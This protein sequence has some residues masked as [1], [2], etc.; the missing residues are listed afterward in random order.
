MSEH[1]ALRAFGRLIVDQVEGL[2]A[3]NADQVERAA[4]L[5]VQAQLSGR[6]VWAAGAG[7]SLGGVL[8]MFFR[9]GGLPSVNPLWHPEILPLNGAAGSTMAERRVGLGRAVVA[10]SAIGPKDVV[11]VFSNSGINHYP[12][13]VAAE[14]R[15]LGAF[16]VAVTSRMASLQA[17]LRAGQRL[18][19]LA[20]VVLDTEVPPGDVVWPPSGARVAPLSSIA[21]AVCWNMVM[22]AASELEPELQ[23]W[24]SANTGGPD[25]HNDR[26]RA[27]YLAKV[28]AL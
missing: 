9:A 20:D 23:T 8:E 11:V 16:V 13:E 6:L 25:D 17:P 22:V 28:P 24:I 5:I 7:H 19:D 3:R 27:R 1:A 21:N 4:R 26:L 2:V 12:V 18:I 14:A 10:G 15:S